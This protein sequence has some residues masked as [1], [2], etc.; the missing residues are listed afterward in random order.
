MSMGT[1]AGA[2]AMPI[3]TTTSSDATPVV[4][5][6]RQGSSLSTAISTENSAIHP[7]LMAPSANS[8]AINAQQQPRHQAP[9]STP[10]HSAPSRPSRQPSRR[11]AR[12]LR[13]LLRQ[14]FFDG[15]S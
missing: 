11:N 10:M 2:A 12:R 6:A 9:C 14:A 13:H 5:R 3:A 4:A 1:R 7:R 15:V 8:A